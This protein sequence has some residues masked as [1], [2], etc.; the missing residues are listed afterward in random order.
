MGDDDM[1][2]ARRILGQG[3]FRLLALALIAESATARLRDHQAGRRENWQL[4][5]AEP[6]HRLSDADLS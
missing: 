6:W 3:D 5:F 4:L 2:M 1:M